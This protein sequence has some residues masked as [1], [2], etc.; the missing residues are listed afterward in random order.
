MEPRPESAPRTRR[1]LALYVAARVAIGAAVIAA[2]VVLVGLS[3]YFGAS[4]A[5]GV[6]ALLGVVSAVGAIASAD[7]S[8]EQSLGG[9]LSTAALLAFAAF[10]LVAPALFQ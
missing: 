4:L 7:S 8:K 3:A 2:L 6:L 5:L 9:S 1:E 10:A